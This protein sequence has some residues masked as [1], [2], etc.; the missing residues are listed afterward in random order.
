MTSDNAH[1]QEAEGP[2]LNHLTVVEKPAQWDRLK[3]LLLDNLAPRNPRPAIRN[4]SKLCH[5]AERAQRLP[6]LAN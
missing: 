4:T 1:C 3:Q 2:N 6:G 5:A